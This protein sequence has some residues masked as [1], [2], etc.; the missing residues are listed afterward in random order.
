MP[1][2]AEGTLRITSHRLQTPCWTWPASCA[3]CI[4]GRA[5]A[6]ERVSHPGCDHGLQ[7]RGSEALLAAHRAVAS[8]PGAGVPDALLGPARALLRQAQT[9]RDFIASEPSTGFMPPRKRPQNLGIAIDQA[10]QR[11]SWLSGPREA[12]TGSSLPSRHRPAGRE[13]FGAFS[14]GPEG[15]VDW[16]SSGTVHP[17][18]RI[19]KACGRCPRSA[20]RSVHRAPGAAA[21]TTAHL[22]GSGKEEVWNDRPLR[23]HRAAASCSIG[24]EGTWSGQSFQARGMKTIHFV[25]TPEGWRMSSLLWDDDAKA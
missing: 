13:F 5:K 14:P 4:A 1:Y 21:E 2:Q 12:M 10:R 23:E 9:R 24:K 8:Q 15:R 20:P 18:G 11:S 17:E 16:A 22:V 6:R 19:I 7:R 3:A 25:H